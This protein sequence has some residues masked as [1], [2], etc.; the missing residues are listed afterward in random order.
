MSGAS[1]KPPAAGEWL[2]DLVAGLTAYYLTSLPVLLGVWFGVGFLN[3]DGPG[4]DPVLACVRFDAIHYID[5]IRNGYSYDPDRRSLVAQFPAYPLIARGVCEVTG[6]T[7][8]EGGLLTANLFLAGAFVFM[9]RWVRVRWPEATAE[10]RLLVLA[11]FGLWPM[12]LWFRMPYAEALFLC[13]TLA[14]LYGMARRWPLVVLA[15]LTGFVTAVRPVGV[16]LTAAFLWHVFTVS[17]TR[18]QGDRETRRQGD[19]DTV[20][21]SLSPCLLVSWSLGLRVCYAPLACWGLLAYMLYQQLAFG[22]PW[23]FVQTQEHWTFGMPED[24]SWQAKAESLLTLE[25]IW[26]LYDPNSQR[27]WAETQPRGGA[28]FSILF[29]NPIF[30]VLATALL[31]LAR[32]KCWLSGSELI[33]GIGLLAIPYLTRAYEMSMGSHAR[34]AGVAVAQ[35]LVIGRAF[36]LA[37]TPFRLGICTTLS[38][39]LCVFTS[40]YAANYLVF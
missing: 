8:E 20:S 30:F 10:Q 26:N 28:L 39:L 29:W 5:I 38:A 33:L 15:L 32:W 16:A 3:R 11:V 18:R 24:R 37:G 13:G 35:Y 25:P 4:M 40:L 31:T 23:A 22:T 9:A 1:L 12:T 2:D 27:Y 14:V 6:L 36:A 7:P 19:K 34:F 17:E 21:V